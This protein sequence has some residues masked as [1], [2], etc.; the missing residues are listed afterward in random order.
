MV[1]LLIAHGAEVNARSA[2][3]D[4]PRQVTA[5]PRAQARPTGGF[6]PLLYAARRGC[7]T[8]RARWWRAA[9]T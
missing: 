4:W 2:V 8:A 9:R 5:E 3:R 6:T 7:A 1:R